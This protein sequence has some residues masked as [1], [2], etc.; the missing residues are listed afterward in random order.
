MEPEKPKT[1]IAPTGLREPDALR[2]AAEEGFIRRAAVVNGPFMLKGSYVMRQQLR[3]G[4]RRIP[5]DL[6]WVGI[7]E[8]DQAALTQWVTAVTETHLD[9]GIRF[10]SFAQN[11]F[12]RMIEYAMD[13]DFPTVN[14][15]LIVWVGEQEYE[16]AGMDVSF[17]LT[18]QP[19]PQPLVFRPQ[20]GE[21][22]ELAHSCALELQL[23]WKIHQ[24]LVRPRFKDMLDLILLLRE[25]AVDTGL[26]WKALEDECHHD[27]APIARFNW[28]LD[29]TIDRHSYWRTGISGGATAQ[30]LFLTW[31][32]PGQPGGVRYWQE[33][34]FNGLYTDDGTVPET[35]ADFMAE[36]SALLV[37][38]GFV[39]VHPELPHAPAP[40]ASV[41]PPAAPVAPAPRSIFSQL[42]GREP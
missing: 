3:E 10:R 35:F 13:D 17:G 9:D 34:S 4:W 1:T 26:I 33:N 24:C 20:S 23:A 7:G 31:R 5:G 2:I 15:D 21:P 32:F 19:P 8:L 14:T 36:L 40:V 27:G 18:L 12:W 16:I 39:R 41:A 37:R 29:A 38:A 30:Q 6:D 25:N 11:A 22:F 42:F 28:L